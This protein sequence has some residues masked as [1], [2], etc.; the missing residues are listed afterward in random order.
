MGSCC[1][2]SAPEKE[3]VDD[4]KLGKITAGAVINDLQ[5]DISD[6]DAKKALDRVNALWREHGLSADETLD[7]QRAR[8][9][10]QQHINDRLGVVPSDGL[11]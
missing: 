3:L 5:M 6:K 10:I 1:S 4:F 11:T 8:P 9:F 2:G 7:L